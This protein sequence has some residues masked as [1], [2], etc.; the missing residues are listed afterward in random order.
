MVKVASALQR[1]KLKVYKA[2]PHAL[3]STQINFDPM[4]LISGAI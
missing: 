3:L 4:L 2:N 1:R